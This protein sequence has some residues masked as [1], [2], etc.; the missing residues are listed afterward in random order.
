MKHITDSSSNLF[1]STTLSSSSN[2]IFSQIIMN[3]MNCLAWKSLLVSSMMLTNTKSLR[4]SKEHTFSIRIFNQLCTWVFF[5]Y[6][7]VWF[8][9]YFLMFFLHLH[10]CILNLERKFLSFEGYSTEEA[11]V[12]YI[13][14]SNWY[15]GKFMYKILIYIHVNWCK[16]W[17]H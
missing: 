8:T 1:Q 5:S 13:C 14:L 3:F 17:I 9:Y 7:C 10:F 11:W 6:D 4:W 15:S 12:H 16:Q 2:Q